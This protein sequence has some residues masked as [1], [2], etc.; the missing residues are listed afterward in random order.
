MV[1]RQYTCVGQ[2]EVLLC[3][4]QCDQRVAG[5]QQISTLLWRLAAHEEDEEEAA[6]KRAEREDEEK[7]EEPEEGEEEGGGG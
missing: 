3:A 1:S 2:Q 4:R 5:S 7:T 6:R